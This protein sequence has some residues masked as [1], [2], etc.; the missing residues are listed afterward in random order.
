MPAKPWTSKSTSSRPGLTA[1]ELRKRT[2][3]R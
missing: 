1:G 2:L 3:I